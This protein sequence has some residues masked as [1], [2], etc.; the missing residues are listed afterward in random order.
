M[1]FC[2]PRSLALAFAVAVLGQ[3]GFFLFLVRSL[4]ERVNFVHTAHGCPH[5][6]RLQ[7]RRFGAKNGAGGGRLC[8][9]ATGLGRRTTRLLS[10]T[11]LARPYPEFICF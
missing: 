7:Q 9:E 2:H 11:T 10:T 4:W 5:R 1:W 8:H 6:S 3:G